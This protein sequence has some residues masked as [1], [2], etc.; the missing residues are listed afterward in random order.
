MNAVVD[1]PLT[2]TTD[3]AQQAIGQIA[4]ELPGATAVF[5]RHKLDFCCGG[6]IALQEACERKQLP[7]ATVLAELN[8]LQRVDV[9]V[10]QRPAAEVIDHILQRYHAVHREQ[11]PELIRM[12]RRVEAVHRESPDVP[13][14]LADHL[15]AME[16]ELLDHMD[17]EENL[18]FPLLKA[19]GQGMA[20]HPI[21]VMRHEHTS[22]GAQLERLLALS[23]D[24]KPPAGAC[25]TW[26]A[27]YAGIAQLSDDLISHIH[28]ENNLLFPPFEPA[29]AS[30]CC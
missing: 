23:H 18:L 6:Q 14:G 26:R 13:T 3:F 7:L 29:P 28:L 1:T 27:L 9:D 16:A 11:L 2:D 19:G 25:N 22:H 4:V 12:A 20:H 8:A 17:K 10:A 5:R 30:R 15:E 24:T 21:A